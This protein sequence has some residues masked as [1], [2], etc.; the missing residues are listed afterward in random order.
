[1]MPGGARGEGGEDGT[2]TEAGIWGSV[3]LQPLSLPHGPL[4]L[5]SKPLAGPL[6]P[7]SRTLPRPLQPERS[8][9]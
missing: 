7:A 4:G 1:M 5:G 6:A 3:G 8:P 2:R 9:A